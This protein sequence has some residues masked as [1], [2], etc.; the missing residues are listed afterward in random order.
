MYISERLPK[1]T[2]SLETKKPPE[3]DLSLIGPLS[4][5]AGDEEQLYAKELETYSAYDKEDDLAYE[6]RVRKAFHA[7]E[8]NQ[9]DEIVQSRKTYANKIFNLV[10][11][12]LVGM[13]VVLLLSGFRCLGFDLDTKVLLALIGGTTLNV[14]GIFT[15]V[16][17]FLF[18]KNGHSILSQVHGSQAEQP[19]S[20]A[21]PRAARS[22]KMSAKDEP[23]T[24][25]R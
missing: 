12:W 18:P 11:G 10:V 22:A 7:R 4:V 13:G 14:L 8:L 19:K 17:N 25:A 5:P 24:P 3:I 1:R 15:I 23:D 2:V 20:T 21:K 9:I 6:R 16:A